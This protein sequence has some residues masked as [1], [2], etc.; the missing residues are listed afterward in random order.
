MADPPFDAGTF[1]EIV[2]EALL[3]AA[4]T[5]MGDEGGVSAWGTIRLL[6]AENALV[7]SELVAATVN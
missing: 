6:G 4:A 7:P 5:P 3:A 2:A 1:H